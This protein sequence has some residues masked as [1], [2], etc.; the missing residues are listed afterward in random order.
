KERTQFDGVALLSAP[1]TEAQK[2]ER[3]DD[4]E[5]VARRGVSAVSDDAVGAAGVAARSGIRCRARRR[6]AGVGWLA[7]VDTVGDGSTFTHADVVAVGATAAVA[8]AAAGLG[9]LVVALA[10]LLAGRD[11]CAVAR[12]LVEAVRASVAERR[13]AARWAAAA[14]ETAPAAGR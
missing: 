8:G 7:L 1:R 11:R 3:D 10:D 6:L 2:T 4:Q 13:T 9:R 12:A 14:A 5:R